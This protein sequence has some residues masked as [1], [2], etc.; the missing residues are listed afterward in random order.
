MTK[1]FLEVVM[2]KVEVASSLVGLRT[3]SKARLKVPLVEALA[4]VIFKVCPVIVGL[5]LVV[6]EGRKTWVRLLRDICTGNVTVI[7]SEVTM[8]VLTAKLRVSW[9]RL[10]TVDV[11]GVSCGEV[12]DP[13]VIPDTVPVHWDIVL[14]LF[15]AVITKLPW[16]I[17]VG[18]VHTGPNWKEIDV[19]FTPVE[20]MFDT[21]PS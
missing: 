19:A 14:P 7:V 4:P 13:A 6:V 20:T 1:E 8:L 10:L 21:T 11:A 16:G 2:V 15:L 5:T 12:R 3:L 9:V 18:G 17:V